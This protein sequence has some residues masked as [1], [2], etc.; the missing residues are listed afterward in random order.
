VS[1]FLPFRCKCF[2]HNNGKN[3]LGKFDARSDE[4]IFVGNPMHNKAYR[5]YNKSTRNIEESI[6]CITRHTRF[7]IKVL[8]I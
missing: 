3:N 5:I 8:G 2:V 4:V 7:I 1:Y 6:L